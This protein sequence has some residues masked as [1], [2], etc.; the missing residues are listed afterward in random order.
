VILDLAETTASKIDAV[1][2]QARRRGG[3][4]AMGMVLT[5]VI[6]TDERSHYDAIKAA[7]DA[8]REHPS[9]IL[10]VINRA[11]RGRARLDAEVRVGGESGPG[12]TVLTRLYGELGHHA[13]SVV[14]PLLL[15]DAPVVVWWPTHAPDVPA[16][17][18]LGALAQRRV[19]DAAQE[20]RPLVALRQRAEGYRPGDTD[21]AWTRATPWRTVLAAALDQPDDPIV[22]GKVSAQRSNPTAELLATWLGLRLG[23]PV[24]S[25]TSKGPG[26]TSVRLKTENGEIALT[27]PDGRLARLARRGDPDR[28]VALSRRALPELLAEELRRLDPDEVYADC[29]RAVAV[30]EEVA[31]P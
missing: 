13:E 11:G 22:A 15:P 9:R 5:L 1:L 3:S 14:I 21:L 29:V 28:M 8:A 7:N 20:S 25:K 4:P 31:T 10:G 26:I 18:P 6:V 30:E 23:V 17:D 16:D 12:E 24:E 2:T 27:R 19:T